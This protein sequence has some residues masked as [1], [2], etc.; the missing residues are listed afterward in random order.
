MEKV[1]MA[2]GWLPLV[3][4][5]DWWG[6]F[7]VALAS[8]V[9]SSI[10]TIGWNSHRDRRDHRRERRD[11]AL[12]VAL[13]LERYARTCRAMMHRA[14]W[15]SA[16]AIRTGSGQ[17]TVGVHVPEFSFPTVEW[18]WLSHKITSVL[19]DFPATVHYAREYV[20]STWEYVLPP[21]V[22]DDVELECARLAKQA[23]DLARLTRQRH[24]VARWRPANAD[25]GLER[26]LDES[27]AEGEAR[28]KKM[29][30]EGAVALSS[31]LT[32]LAG[33]A[34]RGSV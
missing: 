27:I 6:T 30:E 26:Q 24:G 29:L 9:V 10:V 32:P 16:E 7:K 18:K 23:L 19:R 8:S 17:P 25:A 21:D 12:E 22:C 3:Q 33:D 34:P 4:Q 11:A 2:S 5:F 20:S 14:E 15:A 13:S 1:D 28:R 31:E